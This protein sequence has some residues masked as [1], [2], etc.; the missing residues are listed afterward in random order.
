M[1]VDEDPYAV[2]GV[3]RRAS[4]EQIEAQYLFLAGAYHPD[5]FPDDEERQ[6]RGTEQLKRLNAAKDTL[7]RK[8]RDGTLGQPEQD[9][10][11]SDDLSVDDGPPIPDPFYEEPEPFYR[12]PEPSPRPNYWR[13][14]TPPPPQWQQPPPGYNGPP[15]G[16]YYQQFQHRGRNGLATAALICSLIGSWPLG[17]ILGIAALYQLRNRPGQSGRGMAIASIVIGSIILAIVVAFVAGS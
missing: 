15:G 16:Y 7:E 4:W 9:G 2:L 6:A 3:P 17:I 11:V 8:Y 14:P 1:T 10:P 12:E 13:P 5:R